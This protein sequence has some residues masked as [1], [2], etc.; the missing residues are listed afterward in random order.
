MQE[1]LRIDIGHSVLIPVFFWS[2]QS[3]CIASAFSGLFSSRQPWLFQLSSSRLLEIWIT[4]AALLADLALP[5]RSSHSFRIRPNARC[6]QLGRTSHIPG[7]WGPNGN[8][9]RVVHADVGSCNLPHRRCCP[10]A[11]RNCSFMR[12]PSAEAGATFGMPS[13]C[14]DALARM[15]NP[16]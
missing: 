8:K 7:Y 12:A 5:G 1:Q 13:H 2:I 14:L 3:H 16:K 11:H 15:Y 9:L 6:V 10:G 4:L